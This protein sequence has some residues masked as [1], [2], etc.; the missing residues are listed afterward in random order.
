MKKI[1]KGITQ[2]FRIITSTLDSSYSFQEKLSLLRVQIW[3][4][5]RLFIKP[6]REI[7]N[8]RLLGFKIHSFG[9]F[10][11]LY[12][13]NEIFVKREYEISTRNPS[14]MII[15]CGANIGMSILYF[16]KIFPDCRILAFEPNPNVFEILKLNVKQN[17]LQNIELVN[18]CLSDKEEEIDF[19]INGKLGTMEGSALRSRGGN[20][21][22]KVKAIP[23]SGYLTKKADLIK[24][25]IEGAETVVIKDLIETQKLDMADTYLI[26]YHHNILGHKSKLG[27][28]IQ[29]FEDRGFS[30]NIRGG[31]YN[32]GDFQDVFLRVFKTESSD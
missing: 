3:C 13:I 30:V 16:K 31:F 14:P 8:V 7:V 19:F 9:Y 29:S 10:N 18:L 5:I 24:M 12:Q 20:Q 23:L 2:L 22:L 17:G 1:K 6:K 25:D 27:D 26:E 15:D 11:L 21:R 4:L 28:F 32:Q